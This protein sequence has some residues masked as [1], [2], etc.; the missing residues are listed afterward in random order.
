MIEDVLMKKAPK[1][2]DPM[3]RFKRNKTEPNPNGEKLGPNSDVMFDDESEEE[4]Q[5]KNH[6]QEYTNS[7]DY[8]LLKKQIEKAVVDKKIENIEK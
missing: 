6:H 2:W 8:R 5:H 7:D 4:D 3:S 1:A